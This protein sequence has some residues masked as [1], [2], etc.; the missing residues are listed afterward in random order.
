MAEIEYT[1]HPMLYIIRSKNIWSTL[2][3]ISYDKM[4]EKLKE[5]KNLSSVDGSD[6]EIIIEYRKNATLV[7]DFDEDTQSSE[8]IKRMLD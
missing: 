7:K 5:F 1:T 8:M 6:A 4:L 2:T 3:Y